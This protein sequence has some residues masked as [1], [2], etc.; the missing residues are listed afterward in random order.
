MRK[1]LPIIQ[2]SKHSVRLNSTY[3]NVVYNV[4]VR[5]PRIAHFRF[6]SCNKNGSERRAGRR[7]TAPLLSKEKLSV[8]PRSR[9][10]FFIF[11][12]KSLTGWVPGVGGAA[13]VRPAR[14]ARRDRSRTRPALTINKILICSSICPQKATSVRLL[15]AMGRATS[16]ACIRTTAGELDDFMYFSRDVSNKFNHLRE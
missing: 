2:S 16:L 12:F 4:R 9:P 1:T 8:G 7:S 11:S 10:A 6:T 13:Q 3:V 14:H 15:V 5:F